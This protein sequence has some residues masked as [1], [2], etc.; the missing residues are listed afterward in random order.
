MIFAFRARLC[1]CVAISLKEGTTL[2]G[3]PRGNTSEKRNGAAHAQLSHYIS[4]S[5]RFLYIMDK[6]KS[7][8]ANYKVNTSK[9]NK[10]ITHS[11]KI[12]KQDNLC[13]NNNNNNN[14]KLLKSKVIPGTGR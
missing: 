3:Q 13:Y 5:V 12:Q 1:R 7:P 11:T 4:N 2:S 10:H 8:Q 6:L 14:N 9:E